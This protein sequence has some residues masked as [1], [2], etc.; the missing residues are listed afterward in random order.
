M[1][2]NKLIFTRFAKNKFNYCLFL[3]KLFIQY[4]C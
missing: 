2:K 4:N 1:V 3:S